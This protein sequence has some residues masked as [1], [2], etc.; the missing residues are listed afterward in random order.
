MTAPVRS[1]AAEAPI[2]MPRTADPEQA[3]A[4]AGQTVAQ[5]GAGIGR[6]ALKQL[7]DNPLGALFGAAIVALLIFTLN[8]TND[9]ITRL[10]GHMDARFAQ[11][12]ARL[13]ALEDD[14]AELNENMAEL[15]RK[16]TAIIAAL[17]MTDEV[18]AALD[19][20]LIDR[21]PTSDPANAAPG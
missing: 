8:S 19:G 14:V 18:T 10:E 20:R 21:T 3:A 13:A 16:L 11:V 9:R 2:Q 12:D 5:A 17:N 7:G 4:S 15:D 6:R 1:T